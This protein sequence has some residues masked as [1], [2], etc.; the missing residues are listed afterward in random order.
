MYTHAHDVRYVLV[1]VLTFVLNLVNRSLQ[2]LVIVCPSVCLP[3]CPTVFFRVYPNQ[4]LGSGNII[5]SNARDGGGQQQQQSQQRSV[6]R[7]RS[8]RRQPQLLAASRAAAATQ[9]EL[10]EPLM[11]IAA[12]AQRPTAAATA[13]APAGDVEAPGPSRSL[14][15]GN[16]TGNDPSGGGAAVASSHPI[17][18][19]ANTDPNAIMD[20]STAAAAQPPQ[21][22]AGQVVLS[23]PE[24]AAAGGAAIAPSGGPAARVRAAL[25]GLLRSAAAG[26]PTG[27]TGAAAVQYPS[28]L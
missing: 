28:T 1:H 16:T 7:S 15:A 23:H 18:I 8:R 10:Q 21:P 5:R 24:A 11:P 14:P 12:S 13:L 9:P 22:Q 17:T 26:G 25:T 2:V 3:F 19:P 27:S 4:R 6:S 20:T